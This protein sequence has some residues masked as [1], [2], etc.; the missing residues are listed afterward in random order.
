MR[1]LKKIILDTDSN[2]RLVNIFDI[3]EGGNLPQ[4]KKSVAINVSIQSQEKTLSETDLNKIS[5]KI[6]QE[7][8]KKTGGKIR[9]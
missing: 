2:I 6:I 9:T 7:I 1:N 4:D 8:E 3:F 5:Q